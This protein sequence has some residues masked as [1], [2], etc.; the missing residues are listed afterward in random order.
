VPLA[1]SLFRAAAARP[2]NVGA[3][4]HASAVRLIDAVHRLELGQAPPAGLNLR[5]LLFLLPAACLA[6]S[7]TPGFAAL[8][9]AAHDDC[10]ALGGAVANSLAKAL[11]L[12]GATVAPGQALWCDRASDAGALDAER[13]ALV[14]ALLVFRCVGCEF[15][16]FP[17]AAFVASAGNALLAFHAAPVRVRSVAARLALVQLALLLMLRVGADFAAVRAGEEALFFRPL[18]FRLDRRHGEAEARTYVIPLFVHFL[19]LREPRFAALASPQLLENA[20][21]MCDF[22]AGSG[23][24]PVM[25]RVLGAVVCRP[26]L[27]GPLRAACRAYASAEPTHLAS[28]AAV[29]LRVAARVAA[30]WGGR[31]ARARARAARLGEGAD[32]ALPRAGGAA[33]ARRAARDPRGRAE[34]RAARI[35]SR[36]RRARALQHSR[37]RAQPRVGADR[38]V[39]K[40][41]DGARLRVTSP[42]PVNSL[43]VKK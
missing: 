13:A 21:H 18:T 40:G 11:F 31:G 29:A 25:L 6:L 37:R 7:A 30:S 43:C 4:L 2:A 14:G 36:R 1:Q 3:L 23:Y 32:R 16:A 12:A 19:L 8:L 27:A 22:V 24:A 28:W 41:G 33:H 10:G 38:R 35:R 26:E 5:T 42:R 34:P 15:L 20:L 17:T 39:H 9:S